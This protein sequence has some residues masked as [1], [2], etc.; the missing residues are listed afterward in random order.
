MF[1]IFFFYIIFQFVFSFWAFISYR[2]DKTKRGTVYR[3][4][5]SAIFFPV[6]PQPKTSRLATG[7]YN[8]VLMDIFF[9]IKLKTE[10][11][12]KFKNI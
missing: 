1:L 2:I 12:F 8:T 3:Y 10:I 9:S 6:S 7:G 5:D 11:S 4:V